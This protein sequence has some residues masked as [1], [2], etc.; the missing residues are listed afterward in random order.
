MA[1]R[2]FVDNV[3]VVSHKPAATLD[4]PLINDPQTYRQ[5]Q[6]HNF[7][8]QVDEEMIAAAGRDA[9]AK[10]NAA[11]TEGGAGSQAAD[12]GN[13]ADVAAGSDVD[14]VVGQANA[15]RV[16]GGKSVH[17]VPP[18]SDVEQ[19][20]LGL[21]LFL[22]AAGVVGLL[23]PLGRAFHLLGTAAAQAFSLHSIQLSACF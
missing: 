13:G 18:S 12:A 20:W 19:G 10:A 14:R 4:F 21:R 15:A 9:L 2:S 11:S 7:A 22:D 1:A 6:R 3:G 17:M 5:C 8:A 23:V 16:Y